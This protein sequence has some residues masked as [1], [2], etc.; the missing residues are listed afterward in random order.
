[1]KKKDAGGGGV[2]FCF[3]NLGGLLGEGRIKGLAPLTLGKDRRFLWV[4]RTGEEG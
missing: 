4:E 2:R 1:M 3:I